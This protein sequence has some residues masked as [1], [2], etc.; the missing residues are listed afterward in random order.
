MLIADGG[1]DRR[2][3]RC[4]APRRPSPQ[5]RI[6]GTELWATESNLGATPALR[7]AWF[8]A[9]SDAIVQP[10]PHPLPRPLR[11]ATRIRLASLGYDAVLLAV[12]IA[13]ELAARP[14]LP[15]AG[16]ARSG[17]LRRR[18]RRL[19]LRPRRRR[20]A[21]ARSARGDARPA[22]TSSRRRRAASTRRR[23]RSRRGSRRAAACRR[24]VARRRS[25][26]RVDQALGCRAARPRRRSSARAERR[27][28]DAF[29]QP[30]AHQQ[31]LDAAARAGASAVSSAMPWPLRASAASQF[32]GFRWRWVAR[33]A[34]PAVRAG[35]D[36]GIGAVAPV[37]EI[38]AAL[39]AGPGVVGD[40]VGGQAGGRRSSP[41]SARRARR[42]RPGSAGTSSPLRGHR[43]EARAG[44]D[45][46]LV[47]REVAGAEGERAA[48]LGPPRRSALWPGRA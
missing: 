17:R 10:V 20:R 31:R 27:Q 21:R 14:A 24:G 47:E 2:C 18:R 41:G 44:L 39:L 35:A 11:R 37:S 45:G 34:A 5:P 4:R 6:L 19:P 7:G 25:S 15:G 8:A 12:R 3:R 48:E 22:P 28:I 23:D 46:Q 16:A 26:S 42:R 13:G 40:F 1:R 33:A 43:G 32:S 30:Q 9:P 29:A 38:V 36:A